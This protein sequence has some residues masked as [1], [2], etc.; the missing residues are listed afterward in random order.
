MNKV[1]VERDV[2][3]VSCAGLDIYPCQYKYFKVSK[4]AITMESFQAP[5]PA[6]VKR[7]QKALES[8]A[9]A[10]KVNRRDPAK[11]IDLCQGSPE[12]QNAWMSLGATKSVK[13]LSR[14]TLK[15]D[16]SKRDDEL[17]KQAEL[18]RNKGKTK[19]KKDKDEEKSDKEKSGD[20][21]NARKKNSG[22]DESEKDS[23]NNNN[24]KSEK[25]PKKDVEK[26]GAG[27][28]KGTE[29]DA[30]ASKDKVVE[31]KD[32]AETLMDNTSGGAKPDKTPEPES[33]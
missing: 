27:A 16:A 1:Q 29:P 14:K 9:L 31:P 5:L 20:K 12:D 26:S 30:G 10:S 15:E 17:D 32:D 3:H 19:V 6:L 4:D 22:K 33:K 23:S 7:G 21:E 2:Y 11:I 18:A 28:D 24:K 25:E 13:E 8:S